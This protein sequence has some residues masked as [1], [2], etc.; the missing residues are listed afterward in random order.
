M[1]ERPYVCGYD[2]G[3]LSCRITVNNRE[4]GEKVFEASAPYP[5][6]VM[7]QALPDGT[8]LGIDWALQD[9]SD[10][11]EVMVQLM[12]TALDFVPA[13]DIAAIGTDFTNCTVV[14][15]G[16][17]G[18]P[19]CMAQEFRG[20]P[21]AWPLLWKHHAAQLFAARIEDILLREGTPWFPLYGR[22]VS[23]EWLF[24]KM[25]EIYEEAPEV[26]AAVGTFLEAADYIPYWLTGNLTRNSATLGINAFYESGR[27]FP[28]RGLL[29]KFSRGFSGVLAKLPGQVLPVGSRAGVLRADIAELLGLRPDTVVSVGHGD[30]EIAAIGLGITDS[31]SM[32]MVMGTSTCY[33]M[34]YRDRIAFD[35]VC[36]VVR[37]GM[38]PEQAA[39]ESGQPA[40]G[41][42]F[43][44]FADNLLP[45]RYEREAAARK[46]SVLA[47]MDSLAAKIRPGESGLVALDWLNGNRSVLMDY[48]LRGAIAG[49]SLGTRAEEIYR[50]LIESTAFGARKILESYENAGI[51]VDRL[52]AV[53]GLPRK[54][55]VTMQI[56]ADV[57][58]RDII[59]PDVANSSSLGAA[60][61]AAV[62]LEG[63]VGT[64]AAFRAAAARMVHYDSR[65][66]H[67]DSESA[68]VYDEI[69]GAFSDLH[70]YMGLRSGIYRRLN[71]VQT[72]RRSESMNK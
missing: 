63:E 26:Y 67:P 51:A 72:V 23:S 24:P 41:D 42:A 62:A 2:F 65:T 33:Q 19:L 14:P 6:G 39:Y 5:H 66:Y 7:T 60:V 9:P 38:L 27:G 1:T 36:A 4:T 35:G 49:L 20:K 8:P 69:Y 16:H 64:L 61:C 15:L 22:N 12:H 70:D 59:V 28:E 30:S 58:A 53:G 13:D 54:S 29:E 52:Y 31:G 32:L 34:M 45:A 40:V 17:D 37:D 56:Y 68:A 18:K 43:S 10:W 55:P 21:H 44:W 3:T 50:A 71:T 57:L 48:G 11:Q 46:M 47:Y 25:L